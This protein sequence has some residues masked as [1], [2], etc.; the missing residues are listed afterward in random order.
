MSDNV[1]DLAG[2]YAVHALADEEEATF[3]AHLVSCA[4]CREE[5]HSMREMLA[6]LSAITAEDPPPS[7]REGV[8]SSLSSTPQVSPTAD[9]AP[10][11]VRDIGTARSAPRRR[12]ST[13]LVAAAASILIVGG[14]FT[15]WRAAQDD[16]P[17]TVAQQ[18]TQA[19][20]ATEVEQSLVG[21]GTAT[22][23]RS[24]SLGK[25]VIMTSGLPTPPQDRVYQLWLKNPDGKFAPAGL[26]PAGGNQVV[27]LDGNAAS[28]VGA[29]IT[30]EPAG[31][32]PAPTTNPLALFAFT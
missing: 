16:S 29:G 17:T 26:M 27:V 32:S 3:E 8:L 20:D 31:G 22:V 7:L 19:N 15:V 24:S 14:G 13:R 28:A 5:V 21:G 6:D 12:W 10:P 9:H 11:A 23:T 30:V 4:V 18:I 25:A 2:A 1:H